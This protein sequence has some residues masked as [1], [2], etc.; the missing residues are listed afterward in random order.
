MATMSRR[1]LTILKDATGVHEFNEEE[2]ARIDALAELLNQ[3]L[4][5]SEDRQKQR[6]APHISRVKLASGVPC[7]ERAPTE[8]HGVPCIKFSPRQ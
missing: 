1:T 4:R 7:P 3:I 8:E 2:M 5:T 6:V